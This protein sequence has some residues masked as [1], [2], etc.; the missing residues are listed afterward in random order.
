MTRLVIAV[1]AVSAMIPTVIA[2]SRY[3]IV[4]EE[5]ISRTLRFGP[6]AV[7]GRLEVST[8]SG[9]IRVVGYDEDEVDVVVRKTV[10]AETAAD[11]DAAEAA[12]G[13]EM[14][15]TAGAVRLLGHVEEQPGCDWETITRRR[16]RPRYHV[17]FDFDVRVP[18]RTRLRLC[19]VNGG[20]V[21][22]VGTV[23]DFEIDNVNGGIT[24]S[25]MRGSGRAETVNGAVSA[26]FAE[27]PKAASSYKSVNG[28]LDVIFQRTLSANLLMKTFN[29]ALFTDFD[30]TPLPTPASGV[31][32]RN[33]MTVYRG[34]RF[35]GY[36]VGK[37]GPEITLDAFNGSIRIVSSR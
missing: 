21:H 25:G 30:V 31:E 3:P 37:G 15:E 35:T 32:R 22:V 29:G 34:S 28:D 23:G 11:A 27:N 2:Q 6:G 18:R 17:A 24:L 5:K 36:R 8:I 12:V 19:T 4:R 7:E 13:L 1:A 16:T 33:G 14:A 26:E 20:A 9:N 10:R